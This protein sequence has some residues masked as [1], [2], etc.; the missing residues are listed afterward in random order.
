MDHNDWG[1]ASGRDF[2]LNFFVDF[3]KYEAP[4]SNG[5]TFF[6]G[7]DRWKDSEEIYMDFDKKQ[8]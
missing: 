7:C 3:A 4:R 6:Q 8:L 1:G 2:P 5:S